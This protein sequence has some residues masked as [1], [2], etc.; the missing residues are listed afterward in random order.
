MPR[1]IRHVEIYLPLEDN[2]GRPIAES[3]FVG[4]QRELLARYGG[5]T[6][7]QRQSPLEGRWKSGDEF[8]RTGSLSSR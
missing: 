4:V 2:H 3:K 6:S 8:T 7:T 1:V 5:V